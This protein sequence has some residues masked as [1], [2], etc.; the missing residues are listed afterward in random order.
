MTFKERMQ[1]K[2][3]PTIPKAKTKKR[4]LPYLTEPVK[5][6]LAHLNEFYRSYP[7]TALAFT[8]Q[9]R[10]YVIA[11][12]YLHA[13]DL[14]Q[15]AF[16]SYLKYYEPSVLHFHIDNERR[17]KLGNVQRCKVVLMGIS[18]GV[19][20]LL[21]QKEGLPD[22]WLELKDGVSK[23]AKPSENQKKFLSLQ[24]SLGNFTGLAG[25]LFECVSLLEEWKKNRR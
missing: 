22:F 5:K 7:K 14:L 1:Q 6:M 20:D 12:K 25:N 13:E 24:K 15:I 19:S 9:N 11:R 17:G 2:F 18:A 23:K 3:A 16:L 4:T 10:E 21:L 8:K